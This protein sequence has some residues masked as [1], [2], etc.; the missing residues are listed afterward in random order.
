MEED[1]ISTMHTPLLAEDVADSAERPV[2]E[3]A[4]SVVEPSDVDA[5]QLEASWSDAFR[6]H[7]K[8]IRA[9]FSLVFFT[10]MVVIILVLTLAATNNSRRTV[11]SPPPSYEFAFTLTMPYSGL[12]E[13]GYVM[14]DGVKKVQR[15]SYYNDMDVFLYNATGT[16]YRLHPR[17]TAQVCTSSFGPNYDNSTGK[18]IGTLPID[19]FPT[20]GQDKFSLEET[21]TLG[22]VRVD[23]FTYE[24]TESLPD[25][26]GYLGLYKFYVTKDSPRVPVQF[27]FLGHN[28]VF[29]GS[30]FDEYVIEYTHFKR[31][32]SVSEYFFRPPRGLT[33][34]LERPDDDDGMRTS[35]ENL[36]TVKD[37]SEY[38]THLDTHGLRMHREKESESE[39]EIRLQ[40]FRS[41]A[42]HVLM[43]NRMDVSYTLA[44]NKFADWTHD[45]RKKLRGVL[46]TT[47]QD[48]S[49]CER[50]DP[51]SVDVSSLPSSVDHSK[52]LAAPPPDQGTCG[53]CWTYGSTGAIEA[54]ISRETKAMPEKL[55][56]QMLMDC[57][58]DFGNQA[59]EGGNDYKAYEFLMKDNNGRLATEKAYPYLN[60]DG[61]CEIDARLH[62]GDPAKNEGR[63]S[64]YE[65]T[66]CTQFTKANRN[67]SSTE[68]IEALNAWIAHKGP[69]S[70][71]IDATPLDFYFY[72]SGVYSDTKC[73]ST[74]L[75]HS[76]LAVGYFV[77][78]DPAV[79]SYYT[80]RNSWSSNW[81]EDGYVRVLQ[82]KDNV[83]GVAT[84]PS[85]VSVKKTGSSS[86]GP[87][88]SPTKRTSS[89][90][91]TSPT[92]SAPTTS[93]PTTSSPTT[94]SPT[95]SAPT[96][97]S[98]TTSAPTTSSPTTSAPTTS[99]SPTASPLTSPPS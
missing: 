96:T 61:Y 99:S 97:S 21:I 60:Q 66:G 63:L 55:S 13:T 58:W 12:S 45:E 17:M 86:S 16:S 59:C 27:T 71:S 85:I 46:D 47:S 93:S 90:I 83:C 77:S 43:R 10:V 40:L 23:V 87:T 56:S 98:P 67:A 84:S 35:L 88:T 80:I 36:F 82:S 78:N 65:V 31:V 50:V 81:G 51:K 74:S 37:K 73:S 34:T 92:T 44:L 25:D 39:K 28:T 79:L 22:G 18:N 2:D 5:D 68:R 57:S 42:R 70:V 72:K 69:V 32:E 38:S 29:G 4:P 30:H 52:T 54:A 1:P 33:C 94:S 14:N 95:T 48:A 91:T 7:R 6:E 26:D 41:N 49:V 11:W 9:G 76:V 89:P 15:I 75:D 20:A 24:R 64:P 53:S 62:I 8:T 3:E 19:V